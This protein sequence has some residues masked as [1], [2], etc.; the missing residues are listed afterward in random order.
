M[1]QRPTRN[2]FCGVILEQKTFNKFVEALFINTSGTYLTLCARKEFYALHFGADN[3]S[4]H[5]NTS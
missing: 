2:P 3:R 1:L 5:E 4:S